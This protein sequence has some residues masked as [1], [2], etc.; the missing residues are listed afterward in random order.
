M[1]GS[2]INAELI[3]FGAVLPHDDA[4]WQNHFALR[5]AA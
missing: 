5:H 4:G 1:T 3:D 2:F